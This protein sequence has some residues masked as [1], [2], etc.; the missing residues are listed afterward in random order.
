M[1]ELLKKKIEGKIRGVKLGTVEPSETG[2]GGLFNKLKPIDEPLHDELMDKYKEVL[3]N[4]K[5]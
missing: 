5:K 3:K 2:L 4:R 1:R